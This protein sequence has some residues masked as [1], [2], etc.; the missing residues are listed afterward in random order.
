MGYEL[1]VWDFDGT[2]ADTFACLVRAYNA[3]A[4]GRGFRTLDDPVAARHVPLPGL[5]RS[6]GIPLMYLPS[7][8]RVVLTAVR[9]EMASIALFPGIA[10]VLRELGHARRRMGILSSN[11]P[12]NIRACLRGNGV[13]A[14]FTSVAGYS[15]LLGKARGLRRVLRTQ[16]VAGE[17]AVYIGDEVRDVEAARKAGVAVVAVTWGFQSRGLLAA[18]APDHLIDRPE[19]LLAALGPGPWTTSFAPGPA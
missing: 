11:A 14:H 4:P 13:E 18:Q 12:D 1:I 3:L 5:L 6:L 7:F 19:Q 9:R 2:L 8:T 15:R 17:R 16:Q 10:E